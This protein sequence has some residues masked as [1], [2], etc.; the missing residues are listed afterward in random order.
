M[1]PFSQMPQYV[2]L[3]S[4]D[5]TDGPG[6]DAVAI[7]RYHV[8]TLG[9]DDIGYHWVIERIGGEVRIVPGR[10]PRFQGA[11]TRAAGRNRD[12]IGICVVGTFD[13]EPPHFS[14]WFAS[15]RLAATLATAYGIPVENCRGHR[16]FEPR[17]T[18]PGRAWDLDRWRDQVAI[19][20]GK[21]MLLLGEIQ[22]AVEQQQ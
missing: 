18:C 10:H 8:E 2:I 16:E 9:W 5:T 19:Y 12:S 13:H 20:Y 22:D 1:R 4:S 21:P 15:A 7:R 3:H 6:T 17:K 11:H 14:Q